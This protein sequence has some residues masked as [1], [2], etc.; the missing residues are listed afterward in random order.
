MKKLTIIA[1][2][3]LCT[4]VVKAQLNQSTSQIKQTME[5]EKRWRFFYNGVADDGVL[6]G[7]YCLR[8][9]D[10]K[11]FLGKSFYFVNDSCKM[12]KSHI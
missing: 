11:Q 6:D 5:A 7:S 12:I 2:L 9:M 8:Y 1:V 4:L 10:E 3:S